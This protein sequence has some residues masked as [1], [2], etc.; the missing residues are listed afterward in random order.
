MGQLI[1]DDNKELLGGFID[2]C[3]TSSVAAM[4]IGGDEIMLWSRFG[5]K[6]VV[7][8]IQHQTHAVLVSTL[9]MKCLQS[10]TAELPLGGICLADS[11]GIL[12]NLK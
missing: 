10:Q 6:I 4:F 8:Q 1:Y 12:D 7:F 3:D 2:Q 11:I 9:D 5:S